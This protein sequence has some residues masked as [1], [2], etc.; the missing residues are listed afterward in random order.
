M[1]QAEM[2]KSEAMDQTAPR[3]YQ[4]VGEF[5]A[6]GMV[7]LAEFPSLEGAEEVPEQVIPILNQFG[8]QWWGNLI[9]ESSSQPSISF[10]VEGVH[11]IKVD[12]D[13][14]IEEILRNESRRQ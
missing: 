9:T 1:S 12:F 3:L 4:T 6:L 13:A 10:E 7:Q 2:S 8:G 11:D 5:Y 14:V